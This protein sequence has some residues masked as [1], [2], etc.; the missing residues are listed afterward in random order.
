MA[1]YL[2]KIG[3]LAGLCVILFSNDLAAQPETNKWKFQFALGLNSPV[4][5][6][7]GG[8]FEFNSVNFPSLNLGLQHMFT[9][10]W[11]AKLDLGYNR[12]KNADDSP[13]FKLNYTRI[14]L[15]AVYDFKDVLNFM[16]LRM[17]VVAHAGPGMSFSK[18]LSPYSD[19]DYTYLNAL[20]GFELHYGLTPSVSLYTDFSY[21]LGL[22][23]DDKYDVVEDGFS[24]NGDMLFFTV[25]VSVSLSGCYFCD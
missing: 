13:E 21:A 1:P 3:I 14:N 10:Q 23:G 18:P 7:D 22:S 25:G 2:S 8:N 19:N 4:G 16:P 17:A 6:D 11:G 24:F 15:Q 9:A 5:H 12:A 20:A